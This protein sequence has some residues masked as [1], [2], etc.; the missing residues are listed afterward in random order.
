MP[1][2]KMF[3]LYAAG[4]VL[5]DFLLQIT[6]FISLVYLDAKREDVSLKSSPSIIG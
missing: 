6:M 2:V 5:F 3:S 4:A 1:A